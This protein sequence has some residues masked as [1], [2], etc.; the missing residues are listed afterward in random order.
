M[1]GRACKAA[2]VR[3]GKQAHEKASLTS[4]RVRVQGPFSAI[5]I[6]G[7]NQDSES[8]AMQRRLNEH[9]AMVPTRMYRSMQGAR[10]PPV[11]SA[12]YTNEWIF[13]IR[14]AVIHRRDV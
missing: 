6:R 4:I 1:T 10:G 12:L 9:G 5:S 3:G 11:R 8:R 2:N 13:G 7:F 14:L